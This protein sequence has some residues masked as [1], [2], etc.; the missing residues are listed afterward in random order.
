[1]ASCSKLLAQ[2]ESAKGRAQCPPLFFACIPGFPLAVRR[3]RCSIE[4]SELNLCAAQVRPVESH[5][6]ATPQRVEPVH[7]AAPQVIRQRHRNGR[8]VAH[9]ERE[10]SVASVDLPNCALYQLHT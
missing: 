10:Q 1:S 5:E 3:A 9:I 7:I 8:G 4:L 2:A 6:I